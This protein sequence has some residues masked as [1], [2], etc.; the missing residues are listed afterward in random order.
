M[1]PSELKHLRY[2]A[3]LSAPAYLLLLYLFRERIPGGIPFLLSAAIGPLAA[4]C[5]LVAYLLDR[6][7]DD[8]V[9]DPLPLLVWGTVAAMEVHAFVPPVARTGVVPAALFFG[10]ALKFPPTFSVPAILCVDA[11]LAAVPGP[12]EKEIFYTS[13]MALIAGGAGIALRGGYRMGDREADT[14]GRRSPGAARWF[15][16]GRIRETSVFPQAVR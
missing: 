12:I 7:R 11:W 9:P 14:S 5:F 8:R 1:S 15:F 10:L 6:K 13:A 2:A 4:A 16:P 3:G